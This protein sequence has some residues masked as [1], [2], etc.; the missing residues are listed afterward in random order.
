MEGECSPESIQR[1]KSIVIDVCAKEEATCKKCQ[2]PSACR[3]RGWLTLRGGFLRD[4]G[5]MMW[6]KFLF[7]YL[8]DFSMLSACM[9]ATMNF[10]GS[11]IIATSTTNCFMELIDHFSYLKSQNYCFTTPC[12]KRRFFFRKNV[13]QRP[14]I[15]WIL[16]IRRIVST[17]FL[18]KY[19]I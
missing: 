14:K 1:S 5:L 12:R 6:S 10:P 19:A 13:C 2:R 16:R 9:L 18:V 17:K 8:F 11:D 4:G 7:E 3:A 15:A